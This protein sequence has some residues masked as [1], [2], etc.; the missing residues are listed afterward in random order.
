MK[1]ILS[2]GSCHPDNARLESV[3]SGAFTIE[4]ES[5]E[6]ASQALEQLRAQQ[7][8]LVLI[9]RVFDRD[10]TSGVELIRQIKLD[11]EL[12]DFRVMLISDFEEYQKQAQELGALPGIGKSCSESRIIDQI[13]SVIG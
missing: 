7:Y 10:G 3:L 4:F 8:D 9:N 11:S 12:N 13:Q 1:R 5:S 2:V 6:T